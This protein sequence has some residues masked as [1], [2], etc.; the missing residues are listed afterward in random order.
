MTA[1]GKIAPAKVLVVGA[2]VVGLVAMQLAKKKGAMVFGFDV[3]A[4]AKE[5]VEAVGAKFLEVEVEEDG[6]GAGATP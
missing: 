6:S 5:Q 3:R 2:G 4:A 1:A